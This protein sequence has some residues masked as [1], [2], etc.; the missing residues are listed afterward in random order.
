VVE[1]AAVQLTPLVG[2]VDVTR[3]LD[4]DEAQSRA[5]VATMHAAEPPSGA[6]RVVALRYVWEGVRNRPSSSAPSRSSST[7]S[8]RT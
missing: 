7:S 4:A 8:S 5:M 6:G 2:L 3:G 1:G